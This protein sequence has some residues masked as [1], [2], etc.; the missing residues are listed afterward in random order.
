MG[1]REVYVEVE[2]KT[3]IYLSDLGSTCYL[4]RKKVDQEK[5][6]EAFFEKC[7]FS[8]FFCSLDTEAETV[9]E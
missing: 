8:V 4:E 7:N 9:S 5:K 2:V 1:K 6:V 3:E